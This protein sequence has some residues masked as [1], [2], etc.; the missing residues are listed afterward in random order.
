MNRSC[1]FHGFL[2]VVFALTVVLTCLLIPSCSGNKNWELVN[3]QQQLIG[4]S[5][6]PSIVNFSSPE[7]G[8]MLSQSS[9]YLT[10]NGGKSWSTQ[11]LQ[12]PPCLSGAEIIDDRTYVIGCEC[13]SVKISR[14]GGT[15]WTLLDVKNTTMLSF[16]KDAKGWMAAPFSIFYYDGTSSRK[17]G[18]AT[19]AGKIGA[20]SFVTGTEG[21]FIN[22]KGIL[23]YTPDN[24][25]TWQKNDTLAAKRP[26]L[27]FANRTIALRFTDKAHGLLTA[28]DKNKKKFCIL[29][30][31][32]GGKSWK[33]FG[34]VDA[35]IGTPVLSRDNAYLTIMPYSGADKMMVYRNGLAAKN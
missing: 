10:D 27:I 2:R 35:P 25:A 12:T 13:S 23:Y 19:D 33:D 17:I 9:V 4:P 32:D 21:Y 6:S 22:E 3:S 7:K 15:S 30:T 34:A 11:T 20:I 29:E 26:E 8:I 31:G 28:F 14:D 24:G 18:S 5:F 16:D 1:L